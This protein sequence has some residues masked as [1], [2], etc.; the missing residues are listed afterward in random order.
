VT[1]GARQ[2]SGGRARRHATRPRGAA[3][4]PGARR[5]SARIRLPDGYAASSSR[6]PP[7]VPPPGTFEATSNL[8]EAPL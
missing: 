6:S 5:F 7:A 3:T 1:G 2:S 4:G 8:G